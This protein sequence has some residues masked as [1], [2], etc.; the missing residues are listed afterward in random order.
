MERRGRL[1][2]IS[3]RFFD[4]WKVRAVWDSEQAKWWFLVLDIVGALQGEAD[5][6]KNRH[7][8]K[9]LRAQLRRENNQLGS[10]TT[11]LKFV[12]ID[13]KRRIANVMDYDGVIAFVR[14]FPSEEAERFIHWFTHVDGTLDPKSKVRA[15]DLYQ[16]TRLAAFEV[17][18]LNGLLQIHAYLFGG[19]YDFAGQVRT[20]NISKGGFQFAP[21]RHLPESLQHVEA[22]PDNSFDEIVTKY[23]EL[24]ATHPFRDGNGRS[25]RIWLDL[26]LKK[27]L[28]K[29]VDWS[30][31]AKDD[32]LAAMARSVVDPV[33]IKNILK[34]ALTDKID[35]REMFRKSV[36]YSYYYEQEDEI[37]AD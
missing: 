2:K 23:V 24:N 10:L 13:G 31:I 1:D 22:L 8:W 14:S 29:C 33:P 12:H 30:R 3:I 37:A 11:Q 18:T 21:V 34:A 5:E 28:K 26:L 20:V 15:Y 27:R 9:Y 7:H 32:Y 6:E 16:S 19:L 4:D 35:D 17:G 25:M 36:D